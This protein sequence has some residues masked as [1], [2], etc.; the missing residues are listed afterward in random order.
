MPRIRVTSEELVFD[1]KVYKRGES[2]DV[3][4]HTASEFVDRYKQ[5]E[6]VP[7]GSGVE[8]SALHSPPR[9]VPGTLRAAVDA[10]SALTLADKTTFVESIREGYAIGM[11][12]ILKA[13]AEKELDAAI[14]ADIERRRKA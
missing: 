2:L 14:Q 13:K 9:A 8:N 7:D 10:F 12:P 3:S 1:R 5:A 11:E 6:I 4:D